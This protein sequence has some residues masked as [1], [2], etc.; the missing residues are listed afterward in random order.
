ML[1]TPCLPLF[2]K[3]VEE[4]PNN[5]K[6][7]SVIGKILA[8]MSLFPGNLPNVLIQ[9]YPNN[10]NFSDMSLKL[11]MKYFSLLFC[12]Q[13]MLESAVFLFPETHKKIFSSGW[14]GILCEWKQS[15]NLLVTLPATKALCNLDQVIYNLL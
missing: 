8:N 3:L 15:Q 9:N 7:K 12:F 6:I 14:V 5:S 11:L 2:V 13:A 1:T 10:K 4:F